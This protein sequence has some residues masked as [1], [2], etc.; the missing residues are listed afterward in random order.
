M[1][2]PADYGRQGL[3]LSTSS[4]QDFPVTADDASVAEQAGKIVQI[5]RTETCD[6]VLRRHH[7]NRHSATRLGIPAPRVVG[8]ASAAEG[9]KR[10]ADIE[11]ER[12]AVA[13]SAVGM[14]LAEREG[15][16]GYKGGRVSLQLRRRKASR[17]VCPPSGIEE[18]GILE[19]SRVGGRSAPVAVV[20]TQMP[21]R[22]FRASQQRE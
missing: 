22:D 11:A 4:E 13:Q 2:T 15:R 19:A 12:R 14:V 3:F 7:L 17:H 5:V 9:T 10:K 21:R 16:R 20:Q 8:I 1:N 6:I 18:T